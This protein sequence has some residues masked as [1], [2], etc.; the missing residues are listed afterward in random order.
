MNDFFFLEKEP[1]K[2]EG[3]KKKNESE[4]RKKNKGRGEG[5]G[6]Y[7]LFFSP[8]FFFGNQKRTPNGKVSF[9]AKRAKEKYI[10]AKKLVFYLF[11]IVFLIRNSI[12][13]S[14]PYSMRGF[15]VLIYMYLGQPRRWLV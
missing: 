7:R 2:Q 5:Q 14:K 15:C 8:F 6:K 12:Y 11:F 3:M 4:A 10:L 1:E 13:I 9:M